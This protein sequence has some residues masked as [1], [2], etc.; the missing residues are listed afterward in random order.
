MAPSADTPVASNSSKMDFTTFSNVIDGKLKS[1]STT[2]HAINPATKQPNWEVPLSTSAEVDDAVAAARL[3]FKSWSKTTVAERKAALK[4][5]AAEITKYTADFANLLVIEQGKPYQQ[6]AMFEIDVTLKKITWTAI[7]DL[8]EE[9][10]EDGEGRQTIIRYTPLGV[11]VG[12]V[13]WNFPL[14]LA[15]SKISPAVLTGNTVIIKPSPFTP[16]T[17][18]KAVELAQKFFPP[19]VIQVLTGDET[20][21]PMLTNHPGVNKIT[22]TGSTATGKKIM[23][24]ASKTLKR[25]TLELGGNDPAII[26]KS[27]D[28]AT[29]APTIATLAFVNSGQ[30]CLALKRIYIHSS[31]YSAFKDAMVAHTKTFKV[32]EGFEE[33]V[34][35]GPVQ[36]KMQYDIVQGLFDDVEKHGMNVAVG[37]KTPDSKGYF[38]NPTIIDNPDESSRIV[39]EEP[40]GP[41]LPIMQWTDE[42][43]VIDRANNTKMGLGASVWSKDLDEAARIAKQLEAG[44]VWVNSH[45]EMGPANTFAGHKESGMGAENGVEGLKAFCNIQMLNSTK[46]SSSPAKPPLSTLLSLH[47][48]EVA[49]K[50]T[51]SEK[52][53]AFYSGAA[54]DNITR[55]NN[56]SIWD[57]IMFRP[58]LLRNVATVSTRARILGDE[59]EVPVF[60]SPAALAGLSH[61]E[62]EKEMLLML[63]ARCHQTH[64]S[65]FSEI[66]SAAPKDY[67]LFFQLYISKDR[68]KT[69]EMIRQITAAGAKAIFLTIDLP[70]VGK[71]EADERIKNE[72]NLKSGMSGTS[73]GSDA[74]GSGLARSVGSYIDP[75]FCWD[76]IPWLVSLTDIPII[77]KGVQTGADARKAMEAGCK[78]IFVSNH[79]GRALDG[80][81]PTVLTLL[82]LHVQCPEVFEHMEIFV[83]GGLRRGGD[84]LKALCLGATAVGLGRPFMYAVGYGKEGVEHAVNSEPPSFCDFVDAARLLTLVVLK[85]ELETAMQQC[86]LTN[87]DQASPEFLNTAAIDHLV[88]KENEHPYVRKVSRPKL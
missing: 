39:V 20:L 32:G 60:S 85:D 66:A 1:T 47:D 53:W 19:G 10:V 77:L 13:A 54:N 15:I 80:A 8:P 68:S 5:W 76:D 51:F 6:G 25:V 74:K 69:E 26:C 16:Y 82:E 50:Q 55:D 43:E 18:I 71:R 46:M 63:K 2:T 27:V 11:A 88:R 62:G 29:V 84:I 49:A 79:G 61:P 64:L 40:F 67:P 65:Q 7:L 23:E 35:L 4:N 37:G 59:F 3:A 36:N 70:V 38:I 56:R 57:Q 48:I 73:S 83:D 78:G 28:I 52:T 75:S 34:F 30:V 12:I 33:G 72:S 31:I 9:V 86:G 87:L 41:I 42:E 14:F 45:L 58:R 24:S 81:S 21:G 22:F 44:S 17:A